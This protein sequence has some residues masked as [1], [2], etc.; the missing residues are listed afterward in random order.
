MLILTAVQRSVS[1][2][3]RGKVFSLISMGAHGIAPMGI[4]AAGAAAEIFPIKYL[5]FTCNFINLLCFSFFAFQKP[6]RDLINSGT[7]RE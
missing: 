3:M 1:E 2:K 5:I 7:R 4:A 6:F